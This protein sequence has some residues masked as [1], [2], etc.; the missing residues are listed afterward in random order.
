MAVSGMHNENMQYNA[1]WLTNDWNSRVPF[2][3]PTNLQLLIVDLAV[4]QIPHSTE[5]IS[6]YFRCLTVSK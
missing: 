5:P 4:G 3:L 1:Y 6:S 2:L